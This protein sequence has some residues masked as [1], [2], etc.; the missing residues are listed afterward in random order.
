METPAPTD[1][2]SSLSRDQNDLDF[3]YLP[4]YA[5]FLLDNKLEDYCRESLRI[6]R[7]LNIPLLKYF[8]DV[9][10]DQLIAMGMK[11]NA[12]TLS[13]FATNNSQEVIE[14]SRRNWI[15][16]RLPIVQREQVVADDISLVSFSRRIV[17]RY[18]LPSYTTD[19]EYALGVMNDV[20]RF[21]TI[22]DISLLN[23]FIK[24]QQENINEINQKLQ[25]RER[26]LLDAQEIGQ[27]GSFEWD[28][29]G[30]RSNYTPQV[31]KI[32]E[33]QETSNLERFMDDVHPGDREKLSQALDIAMKTGDYSCEY[34]YVR[35]GKEKVIWS[36]GKVTFSD[37]GPTRMVGT[38]MDVTERVAS[39]QKLLQSENL[40]K[41]AQALTH[42]GNWSWEID[43][44]KVYWSDEMYRIYG[45]AP[46]SEQITLGRFL[47][48]IHPDDKGV[49]MKELQT[50]LETRIVKEYIF[51]I[52]SADGAT[53][54]L[55]GRGDIL[56]DTN[57]NL[58]R[59]VGTCQDVTKEHLLKQSLEE[60][61]R[62]LLETNQELESF[63]FIASH[64]LQEPLR[65]I[66]LYADRILLDNSNTIPITA[67]TNVER[68]SLAARRMQQLIEDFLSFSR[69]VAMEKVFE[70]TD[71]N[72]L[73]D[74]VKTEL[75][76][77]LAKK[78][79]RI[80]VTKLPV[81]NIIPFQFR[82]L[83]INIIGNSIKYA[84]ED[85][86]LVVNVSGDVVSG[87]DIQDA[88]ISPDQSYWRIR[89]SDN[90]IGFEQEYAKKIFEVFQRL[91]PK[92]N[93]SGTG[94]GLSIVKKITENHKGI[95]TAHGV[96]GEGAVFCVFLPYSSH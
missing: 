15:A 93:Y 38:I 90:G 55:R 89:F 45:L 1:P 5:R 3:K 22:H 8:D 71:L 56:T 52:V 12:E 26:E 50:S 85:V 87:A 36:R 76:D 30:K 39:V 20:D 62:Q 44:D 2:V 67:R 41:Q 74:D 13:L 63:N 37:E 80:N 43:Q 72:A 68:M 16:N 49:R 78:N 24:S 79:G 7:E 25:Q 60:T 64:D 18:F 29:T 19:V 91:H 95:I 32:F 82:Q 48:F 10:D 23:A 73:L 4:D 34:R 11:L 59:M 96:L 40:S 42:I 35:G 27:I 81:L 47:S 17:M 46:Q 65:K 33:M 53:K 9:P 69:T 51:R 83:M 77:L 14:N 84:K 54:I 6:S 66:R 28:F 94:I 31:Y 75:S 86:S 92:D 88:G 61:N 21:T 70:K 58:L 57:N